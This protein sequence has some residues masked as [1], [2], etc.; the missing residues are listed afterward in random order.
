ML[1][2]LIT[3]ACIPKP[4][5]RYLNDVY[6]FKRFCMDCDGAQG[7]VLAPLNNISFN[8]VFFIKRSVV[9]HNTTMLYAKQYS[10][11]SQWEP[12]EGC[13]FLLHFTNA[14]IHDVE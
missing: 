9:S 5:L 14:E 4:E 2:T 12:Q 3:E 8:H 6:D 1:T 11:S 10:F 7:R 13:G